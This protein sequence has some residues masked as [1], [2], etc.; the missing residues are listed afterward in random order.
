VICFELTD[1]MRIV[2]STT[3]GHYHFYIDRPMRR[4]TMLLLLWALRLCFVIEMGNF[5]W[6]LRRGA[7]FVRT[8][9]VRKTE[10]EST[11]YT[12]GMFF[13]LRT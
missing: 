1:Q 5:W 9:Y 8:P 12:Y 6:S 7:T 13:K 10:A 4:S 11:K 3:P 2:P